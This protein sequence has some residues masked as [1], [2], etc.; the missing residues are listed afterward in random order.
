Q[1]TTEEIIRGLLEA[2]ADDYMVKP[3]GIKELA[4]RVNVVLR[5]SVRA[6]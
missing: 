3:F 4:A 5:R 1:G 2:G 6:P